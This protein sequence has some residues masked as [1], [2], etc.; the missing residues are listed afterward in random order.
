MKAPNCICTMGPGHTFPNREQYMLDHRCPVHGEK[1]MPN[2]WGRHTEL[3]LVIDVR[4]FD[5]LV[6]L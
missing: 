5:I 3:V 1:M 4:T 6:K 2:V